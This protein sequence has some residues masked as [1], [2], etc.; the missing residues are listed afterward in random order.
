MVD[1]TTRPPQVQ[2]ELIDPRVGTF[3]EEGGQFFQGVANAFRGFAQASASQQEQEPDFSSFILALTDPREVEDLSGI[4][5]SKSDMQDLKSA[6][7]AAVKLDKAQ[8]QQSSFRRSS[9]RRVALTREFIA[10]N[11]QYAPEFLEIFKAAQGEGLGKVIAN[12]EKDQDAEAKAHREYVINEARKM[13][14]N[15]TNESFMNLQA[16]VQHRDAL[17]TRAQESALNLQMLTDTEKT[18]NIN[19]QNYIQ[20]NIL[21]GFVAASV[22]GLNDLLDGYDPANPDLAKRDRILS[23]IAAQ[24]S[25]LQSQLLQAG[26]T[27]LPSLNNLMSVF[28][29]VTERV[30]AYLNGKESLDALKTGNELLITTA[31]RGWLGQPNIPQILAIGQHMGQSG[32]SPF[33]QDFSR[34]GL[35]VSIGRILSDSISAITNQPSNPRDDARNLGVTSPEDLQQYYRDASRSIANLAISDDPQDVLA[36]DALLDKYISSVSGDN[37]DGRLFEQILNVMDR[38]EVMK[39]LSMSPDFTNALSNYVGDITAAIQEDIDQAVGGTTTRVTLFD[40]TTG[41]PIPMK[42]D[43]KELIDWGIMPETGE[44]LFTPRAL[45]DPEQRVSA[46][47]LARNL[48][49]KYSKRFAKL[50]NVIHARKGGSKEEIGVNIL[51]GNNPFRVEPVIK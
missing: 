48:N 16:A 12:L 11:P 2:P 50:V 47:R 24:K 39:G 30:T 45:S 28:D 5:T 32:I 13:G 44:I 9:A 8:T 41:E 43:N 36:A 15:V 51:R 21:P 27:D 35:D 10:A 4:P 3:R 26:F 18:K 6:A 46:S 49:K 23:E 25:T 38:P 40:P 14:R 20:K 17:I 34:L 42:D 19:L 1:L 31:E 7:T 33:I 29:S 22:Q 37:Y